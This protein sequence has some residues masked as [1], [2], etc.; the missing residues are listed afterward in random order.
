[1]F[2]TVGGT[3]K[4]KQKKPH[5]T[6][7]GRLRQISLKIPINCCFLKENATE[8]LMKLRQFY[9]ELGEKARLLVW[10]IKQQ[11]TQKIINSVQTDKGATEPNKM[12]E[13]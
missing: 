7:Q 9:K 13:N 3:V 12:I 8:N 5:E 1:M 2:Q 4:N 10:H 6:E 11:E